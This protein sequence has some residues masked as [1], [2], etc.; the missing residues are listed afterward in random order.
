MKSEVK[1]EA[2]NEHNEE[3]YIEDVEPVEH[4]EA[5][6][7]A[8]RSC[9]LDKRCKT[10]IDSYI[11]LVKARVRKLIEEQVKALGSAKVQIKHVDKV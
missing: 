9:R 1:E 6:N 11:A 3:Y 5:M 7:G 2:E 4:E 10:D 8:Y